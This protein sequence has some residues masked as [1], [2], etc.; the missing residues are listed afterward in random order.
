QKSVTR[1][2]QSAQAQVESQNFESRKN[3]LKYD[4]V[5]SKQRDV[6][7]AERREVLEGVDL[8]GLIRS[9]IDDAVGGYVREATEGFPEEW[10]LNALSAAPGQLYPFSSRPDHLE[11]GAGGVDGLGPDT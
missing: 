4:D 11:N 6:I 9:M 3:V 1:A 8:T 5:M 10:D 2:I 7:Y